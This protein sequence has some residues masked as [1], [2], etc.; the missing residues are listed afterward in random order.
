M[1]H[2]KNVK[3]H[4]YL[5]VP[6]HRLSYRVQVIYVLIQLRLFTHTD[7]SY[8]HAIITSV[9]PSVSPLNLVY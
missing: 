6:C 4:V 9:Y 8:S 5:H 7:L 1:Y 2:I 3:K